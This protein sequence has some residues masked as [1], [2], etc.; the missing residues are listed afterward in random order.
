M[1]THIKII[2]EIKHSIND[3][4]TLLSKVFRMYCMLPVFSARPHLYLTD[5]SSFLVS[6]VYS[7]VFHVDKTVQTI[8]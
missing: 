3:G 8:N 7:F 5:S 1:L 4:A 2:T 6:F